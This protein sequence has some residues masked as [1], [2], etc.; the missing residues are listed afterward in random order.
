[1]NSSVLKSSILLSS[2]KILQRA[3][4]LISFL[5]LARVLTKEDFAIVAVVAIVLFLFESLS[6]LGTESYIVQKKHIDITDVQSAWTTELVL[7]LVCWGALLLTAPLISSFFN[8][9][10]AA[11][12]YVSS[13]VL[14]ISAFKSPGIHVKK[15]NLEYGAIFKLSVLQKFLSF[16]TVMCIVIIKP[17]YWAL[18]IGDIVAALCFSFGSHIIA[19][20][21]L[22]LT[23]A[24]FNNQWEFSKWIFFRGIIGYSKA[25]LD[26]FVA[27]R[28]FSLQHFGVYSLTKNVTQI[29]ANDLIS[30]MIEPLL[31]SLA[32]ARENLLMFNAVFARAF[33]A[34]SLLVA[35]ISVFLTVNSDSVIRLVMGPKWNDANAIF[36]WFLFS[37]AVVV[38]GQLL[39][40]AF[41]ALGKVKQI[42]FYE[43]ISLLFMLFVFW[44]SSASLLGFV[45][46]RTLA[47]LL[48]FLS[49][50]LIF[51]RLY[52]ANFFKLILSSIPLYFSSLLAVYFSNKVTMMDNIILGFVIQGL[53]FLSIY[54]LSVVFIFKFIFRNLDEFSFFYSEIQVILKSKLSSKNT[55]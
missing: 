54:I 53:F 17:S 49:L 47:L 34:I 46:V 27:G 6:V 43:L 33:F 36:G 20:Y 9:D 39:N 2:I 38:Y 51:S 42:F 29:P 8:L 7:K 45:Q 15:R 1:M 44:L 5:V 37:A 32:R 16:S 50:F 35:P 31:V 30:P 23:L 12:I 25:Q 22:K 52:G 10:S 55:N 4:G 26:S 14:L 11:V 41:V 28:V 40:Q 18:V 21:S 19:P 48:L 13:V 24:R 3:L